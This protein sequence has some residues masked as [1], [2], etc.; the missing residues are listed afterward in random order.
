VSCGASR[1]TSRS[2]PEL[3]RAYVALGSNLGDRVAALTR[4]R[5][6]LAG[7]PDTVLCGA[8]SIEET[9]PLG[10][11]DQPAYLNQMVALDTMLS[12]RDLLA[13]FHRIEVEAGRVR[14][15]RWESRTLDLDLVRY[16]ELSLQEPG[17]V[18]PHPGLPEREF[19]RRELLELERMGC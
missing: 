5:T 2:R 12:P 6:R 11:L 14:R 9:A 8:S 10:G 16:G 7:L 13:A 15:A 19:W 1:G 3:V 4:A 18:L 17:L